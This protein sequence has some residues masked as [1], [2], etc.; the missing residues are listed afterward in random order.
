MATNS[1]DEQLA[2]EE[3]ASYEKIPKAEMQGELVDDD[4]LKKF[5]KQEQAKKLVAWAKAEYD[6]C[7][8][9][10][11]TE[12]NDW[13]LNL[14]F[15][16]GYQYHDWRAIAGKQ[17]LAEEPNPSNLPRITVNRIEP[18]IR[19]EIA[20]TTAQKPSATVVPASNDE[21]D[22]LSATAGEQVWESIYDKNKF[23][24]NV[25]QKA[26]FW[27]AITGNGFIKT[28]WDSSYKGY[29]TTK[30]I[31]QMTGQPRIERRLAYTGD[32]V[33][34]A[35]S[36][37]HVFVPDQ[38]EEDIERQPYVLN[39][40]TKAEEWV[41]QMFGSVLPKDFKPSKVAATEIQDSALMDLRGVDNAKPDAV[42]IIEMWVKPGTTKWLPNGGLIT[43][44]DTEIVQYSDTGIPYHHGQFPFSH[45]QGIAN[46][47]F[48]R[49]SVIK[50]L[51]PLQREYNRTRSQI[52]HAKNLMAK[53]QMMYDEGSVDP[54]KITARAGI[55]I[56]VRPG[57]AKPTP[58]PIQALPSY[59]LQEVQQ[60]HSDFEDLSGQH[61]VSR[62]E[63]GGLTA[64]TAIAYLGERDD[65]Y[66]TTIFHSIE[67]AVEK[68]AKQSLGLFVQYVE[69]SRLVKITGADGSFDAMMLS[70]A[71]LASGTDIRIESGSALPTSK[72]ARQALVTEWMKMGFI[73]PEDGLRILEMGMLKQYYNTIKIDENAAQ[74]ENL[75]IKKVTEEMVQE[76]EQNWNDGAANGDQDKVDPTTGDAMQVPPIVSVNGWDNHAV[77][78]E[79][80][81]RFR[82]SQAYQALPNIVKAEFEKHIS[83][84]EQ[85]LQMQQM[86]QLQMQQMQGEQE[87]SQSGAT[88]APLQSGMTEEQLG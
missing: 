25:L 9:A 24:T 75:M 16:N 29:E 5:K 21:D 66:L 34:E 20:K 22:L 37:F 64:A 57:F 54:R 10:R 39:V 77:H 18:V 73:P 78:M 31:D 79:I 15:Y 30:E 69:D 58:V 65:A 35:V 4:V 32:V 46:G 42:L 33:H 27:R 80:H 8:S 82:K 85:A 38:S 43:I 87:S 12:E 51:I 83:M 23:Q 71:D 28:F 63:S 17:G 67:A 84:H 26:E 45:L 50:N 7:K 56:P 81:N 40:Y 48:Y 62:G 13:Y 47:K 44:V 6:K 59:V 60:L 74:R 53:P 70:G 3:Q 72:A 19:T 1:L 14:A 49:R 11:K 68:V 88:E 76:F 36:P 86:Q 61:Q 55:W 2:A 41:R 52:V